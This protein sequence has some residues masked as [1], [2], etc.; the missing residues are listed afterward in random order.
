M[1]T[2]EIENVDIGDGARRDSNQRAW[3]MP[4]QFTQPLRI[5]PRLLEAMRRRWALIFQAWKAEPPIRAQR[6][7]GISRGAGQEPASVF[8]CV[9]GAGVFA[10]VVVATV[11][12]STGSI[13][14]SSG[15]LGGLPR[16]RCDGAVMLPTADPVLIGAMTGALARKARQSSSSTTVR[17][18]IFLARNLPAAI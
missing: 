2:I 8:A 11:D 5:A 15:T 7:C 18:P 13:I 6:Q 10:V 1:L 16:D 3:I 12:A 9:L 14:A 17:R 4:P